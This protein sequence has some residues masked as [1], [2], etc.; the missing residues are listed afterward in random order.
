MSLTDTAIRRASAKDKPY[1]M[2]DAGGRLGLN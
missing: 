2:Y 1:K